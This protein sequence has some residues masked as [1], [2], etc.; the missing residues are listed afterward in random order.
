VGQKVCLKT[1]SREHGVIV[2]VSVTA[3]G[4]RDYQVFFSA[5]R[6]RFVAEEDLRPVSAVDRDEKGQIR[7]GKLE[8][9]LRNLAVT[10]LSN[11]QTDGLYSLYASRTQFEVYQFKPV[12]KFLRN[13]DQRLLIADEV[14]LG[15]TIEAGIIM[16][17]LQARV[18]RV[19][20]LA[21]RSQMFAL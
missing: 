16:L 19:L 9:L 12:L 7:F 21:R 1:K 14:G 10:K 3:A 8:D 17:E 11:P 2:G 13:P 15:K 4:H 18:E 20:S 5:D 6:T